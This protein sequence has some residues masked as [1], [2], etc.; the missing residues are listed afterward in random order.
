MSVADQL[1]RFSSTSVTIK[2]GLT[3]EV[4][5]EYTH[6]SKNN[7]YYVPN[8]LLPLYDAKYAFNEKY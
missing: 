5:F 7:Y 4:H 8:K 1:N 2:Y 6:Y 3:V